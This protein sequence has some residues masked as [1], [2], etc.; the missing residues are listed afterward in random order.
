V[1]LTWRIEVLYLPPG[2]GWTQWAKAG[3]FDQLHLKVLV[4]A[5]L[6]EGPKW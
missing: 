4:A 5:L 6:Q 1:A 2:A 3:V